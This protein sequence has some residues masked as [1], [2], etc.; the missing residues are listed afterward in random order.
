MT[1]PV[2][3]PSPDRRPPDGAAGARAGTARGTAIQRLTFAD[4]PQ[5]LA[6]ERRSYRAPWSLA[7]FVLEVAKPGGLCIVARSFATGVA[8]TAGRP[9]VGYAIVSRYDDAFHVMNVCVEPNRRR[10]GIARALLDHVIAAAGGS[11]ARLTLEVRPSN[12]A[13]RALYDRLGFLSVGT[14]RNYYRDDGEDALIMWRTPATLDGRVDDVPG[15]EGVR[16]DGD[17][18]P[19]RSGGPGGFPGSRGPVPP[20]ADIGQP[21]PPRGPAR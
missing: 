19:L 17:G 3:S 4:L 9:L 16:V 18:R 20:D 15:A 14:R 10:E 21:A 8:P 2:P 5:V 11:E 12:T 13:A 6:I 7:M 1:P